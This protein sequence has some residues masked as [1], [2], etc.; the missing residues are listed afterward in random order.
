MKDGG[1]WMR[2]RLVDAA[3]CHHVATEKNLHERGS[4]AK[5]IGPGHDMRLVRA[6]QDGQRAWSDLGLAAITSSISLAGRRAASRARTAR[7]AASESM[8]GSRSTAS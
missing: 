4:S 6:Y 1:A 8:P 3:P 2:Q 5:L 7:A